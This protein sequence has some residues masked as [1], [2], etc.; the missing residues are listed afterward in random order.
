MKRMLTVVVLL[1]VAFLFGHFQAA[2]QAQSST[3]QV[4]VLDPTGQQAIGIFYPGLGKI[5]M[6]SYN[7]DCQRVFSVPT[8]A[9]RPLVATA[10]K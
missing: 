5:Y 6:Y 3:P 7:G 8:Q 2:P 1:V 4:L 10:C 9:G